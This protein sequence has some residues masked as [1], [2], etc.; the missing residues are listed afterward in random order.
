G[1]RIRR[2]AECARVHDGRQ[3]R[4]EGRH[5]NRLRRRTRCSVRDRFSY[6]GKRVVVTGAASGIGE[7]TALLVGELGAD[8]VALD[9]RQPKAVRGTWLEVNLTSQASIDAALARLGE[10]VDA[11]FN[12]A[13]L[14]G[15]PFSSLDTMLVNFVALRYVSESL[16][17]RMKPGSAIASVSSL[18]GMGYL[19]KLAQLK[20]L[21]ETTSFDE[22]RTWCEQHPEV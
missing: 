19:R 11:L 9:L 20:P 1:L 16:A 13:G 5:P 21:L 2:G 8:V 7:A 3:G 14:P 6:A 12:C 10:P 22:A 18:G 17:A 4:R 15:P